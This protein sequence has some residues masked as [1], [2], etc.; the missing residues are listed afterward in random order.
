MSVQINFTRE[1]LTVA[2]AE[3]AINA[4]LKRLEDSIGHLVDS[5]SISEIDVTNIGSGVR[6]VIASVDIRLVETKERRW[7]T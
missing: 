3:R 7:T 5:I 1:T 2:D 4:I 6:D